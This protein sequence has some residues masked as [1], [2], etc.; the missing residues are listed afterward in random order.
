MAEELDL[1]RLREELAEFG[2]HGH[3]A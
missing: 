3:R 2:I 1:A